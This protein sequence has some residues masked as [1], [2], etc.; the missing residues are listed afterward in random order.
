M[1]KKGFIKGAA[2]GAAIAGGLALLFAPKAGKEL[3]EDIAQKAKEISDDLDKKI[4]KAKK[5]ASGLKGDAQKSKLAM[6]EKAETLKAELDLKSKDFGN[7]SKRVSKIAAREA[8]KLIQDGKA[9]AIELN[10]HKD[11]AL[12]ETQKF[13]GKASKSAGKVMNA[14]S[15]E[16]KKDLATKPSKTT[17]NTKK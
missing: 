8:D 4:S 9:L 3:R 10:Q 15:K 5:D 6:I 13:V 2:I 16:V 14:A 11:G 17:K 1:A 7:S 12:K